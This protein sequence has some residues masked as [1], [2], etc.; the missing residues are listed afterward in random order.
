MPEFEQELW[1]AYSTGKIVYG[2]RK[3]TKLLKVGEKDAVRLVIL[4]EN[5]PPRIL[6]EVRYLAKLAEV[7]VYVYPKK[8][9]EL[10][11]VLRKPFMITAIAV[12]DPGRSKILE[13]AGGEGA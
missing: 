12:L 10:G 9:I 5:T 7:P 1:L 4:A 13:I 11:R 3:V 2:A 8:S 6:E